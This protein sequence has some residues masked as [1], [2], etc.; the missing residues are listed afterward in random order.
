MIEKLASIENI[1]KQVFTVYKK[2]ETTMADMLEFSSPVLMDGLQNGIPHGSLIEING[3]R[4]TMKSLLAYDLIAQTQ[5]TRKGTCV[6]V[7][8]Y[9]SFNPILASACGVDVEELLIINTTYISPPSTRVLEILDVLFESFNEIAILVFDDMQHIL[10]PLTTTS[11][12]EEFN[13]N[14][15]KLFDYLEKLNMARKKFKTTVV[16]TMIS[17]YQYTTLHNMADICVSLK[18]LH[19]VN[20]NFV[21]IESDKQPYGEIFSIEIDKCV[22][23]VRNLVCGNTMYVY[24]KGID[25]IYEMILVCQKYG[26]IRNTQ[27]WY[28]FVK[29]F[30]E[31]DEHDD[32]FWSTPDGK[33]FTC[34]GIRLCYEFLKENDDIFESLVELVNRRRPYYF[35]RDYNYI[36][37]SKF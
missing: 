23:P 21:R 24:E 31:D 1:S 5:R 26:V 2:E 13:A 14:N 17:N 4:R 7:D 11:A 9:G 18:S 30:A 33:P 12:K 10:K 36:P 34:Q 8:C 28:S 25:Y 29:E 6:F 20:E 22:F 37:T 19:K 3:G 16:Y 15:T 35:K 32:V 27:A